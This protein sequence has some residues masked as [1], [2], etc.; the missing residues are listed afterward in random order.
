MV[1]LALSVL[2]DRH[3]VG[4]VLG[5]PEQTRAFLRLKLSDRKHEVFGALFLDTRN[6]VI[7]VAEMFQG[8]IDGASVRGGAARP[9]MQRSIVRHFS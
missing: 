8:T 6:R 9:R 4:R 7:Q 2:K 1:K 5:S 3:R